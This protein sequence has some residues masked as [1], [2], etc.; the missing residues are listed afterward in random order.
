MQVLSPEEAS[1]SFGLVLLDIRD[2]LLRLALGR[3]LPQPTTTT[4]TT[5]TPDSQTG[6]KRPGDKTHDR[7]VQAD[8][9]RCLLVGLPIFYPT[10]DKQV[11]FLHELLAI[12]QVEE[13]KAPLATEGQTPHHTAHGHLPSPARL[14]LDDLLEKLSQELALGLGDMLF[15]PILSEVEA[16]GAQRKERGAGDAES[17][18][19]AEAMGRTVVTSESSEK[20]VRDLIELAVGLMKKSSEDAKV[21]KTRME[22]E[23]RSLLLD[24]EGSPVGPTAAEEAR[25][26]YNV[27]LAVQ[28]DLL[29]SIG[30]SPSI[31]SSGEEEEEPAIAESGGT[32]P[33]ELHQPQPPASAVTLDSPWL[34]FIPSRGQAAAAL[35]EPYDPEEH[36]DGGAGAAPFHVA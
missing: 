2:L 15:A 23:V 20:L 24:T 3:V 29:S 26:I 6:E 12:L 34:D 8:A 18:T 30:F 32:N 17:S 27:L 14:L 16:T 10:H 11:Q 28:R 25:T 36:R 35:D 7:V 31:E 22:Q 4:T 1:K 9:R 33:L 13:E 5:T 19:T 21:R